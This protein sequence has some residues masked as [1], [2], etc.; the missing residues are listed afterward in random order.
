VPF[1]GREPGMTIRS[2]RDLEVWQLAMRLAHRAYDCTNCLSSHRAVCAPAAGSPSGAVCRGQH[3]GR[4]GTRAHRGLPELLIDVPRFG[5][6]AR[7]VP[8]LRS[9]AQLSHR[10]AARNADGDGRSRE[11]SAFEAS[12]DAH[13]AT[14]SRGPWLVAPTRS[15]LTA[16]ASRIPRPAAIRPLPRPSTPPGSTRCARTARPC[17]AC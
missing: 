8:A 6:G 3:R 10:G 9:R 17:A 12:P 2:Y 16:T 4:P 15:R 5:A 14:K 13:R 11:S 7:D 1:P